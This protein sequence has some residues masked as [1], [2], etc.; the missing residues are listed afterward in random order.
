V[1]PVNYYDALALKHDLDYLRASNY[2]DI[3]LA[4]DNMIG[5]MDNGN[6]IAKYLFRANRQVKF[7]Q[8]SNKPELAN[9]L[10]HD[11]RVGRHPQIKQQLDNF[12][13]EL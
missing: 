1:P 9:Q 2:D 6:Q 3:K 11:I 7:V 4:D 13:I 12:K 8:P 10:K 5:K